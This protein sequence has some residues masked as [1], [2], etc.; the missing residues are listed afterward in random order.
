MSVQGNDCIPTYFSK[1]RNLLDEF[2]SIIPPSCQCSN[3]KEFSM[4]LERQKLMQFL[5]G[6]T[7]RFRKLKDFEAD[8]ATLAN[9]GKCLILGSRHLIF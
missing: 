5:M 1:I 3:S 9:F 2:A 7:T 8:F 4:H 6:V